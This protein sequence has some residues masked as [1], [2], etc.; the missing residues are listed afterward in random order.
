FNEKYYINGGS[1]MTL[2]P[3]SYSYICSRCKTVFVTGAILETIGKETMCKDCESELHKQLFDNILREIDLKV[4]LDEKEFEW[5]IPKQL[6][7]TI[8]FELRGDDLQMIRKIKQYSSIDN[9][10]VY[11]WLCYLENKIKE[12][13]K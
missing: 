5:F 13:I 9:E 12:Q 2:L 1:V 3:K 8:K 10:D 11:S 4:E 6:N 7:K